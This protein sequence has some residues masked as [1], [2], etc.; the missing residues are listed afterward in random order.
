MI[1]IIFALA[2]LSLLSACSDVDMSSHGQAMQNTQAQALPPYHVTQS[3][4]AQ[5]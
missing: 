5:Q 4:S 1:K 2:A 3:L